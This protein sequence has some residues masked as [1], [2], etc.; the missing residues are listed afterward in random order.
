MPSVLVVDHHPLIGM[1]LREALQL[2]GHCVTLTR[3]RAGAL[4]VLAH[5]LP[6][7]VVLDLTQDSARSLLDDIR[8][9]ARLAR[10]PIVAVASEHVE[11]LVQHHAVVLQKPCKLG[12]ILRGVQSLVSRV[13]V[14]E[15]RRVSMRVAVERRRLAA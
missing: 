10:V 4:G 12:D 15:R 6:A 14:V 3:D 5:E 8:N 7:V 11:G 13:P 9:N 2:D 1:V